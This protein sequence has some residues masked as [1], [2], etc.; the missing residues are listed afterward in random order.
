V[1]AIGRKILKNEIEERREFSDRC[2]G[3][4]AKVVEVK[5]NEKN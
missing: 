3:R 2:V 1:T 4:H 5:K